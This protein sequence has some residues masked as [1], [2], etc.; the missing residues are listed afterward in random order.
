VS[1]TDKGQESNKQL[2]FLATKSDAQRVF[3]SDGSC[4]LK[5]KHGGGSQQVIVVGGF[6]C[7]PVDRLDDG[8]QSGERRA[9]AFFIWDGSLQQTNDLVYGHCLRILVACR[10]TEP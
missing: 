4:R 1:R 2:E 3:R 6:R 10:P 5:K 7:G 8:F 9:R